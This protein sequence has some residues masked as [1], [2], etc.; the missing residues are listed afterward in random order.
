MNA[1][2]FVFDDTHLTREQVW[3]RLNKL[4]EIGHWYSLF[5]NTFCLASEHSAQSLA[6]R[7]REEIIPE[8]RFLIV[9]IDARKKG[10]WLPREIWDFL[11]RPEASSLYN[12]PRNE[13]PQREGELSRH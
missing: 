3:T 4:P 2:L 8:V 9:E 12:H 5:G 1:F 6:A 13:K 10:G 7:V 11:D